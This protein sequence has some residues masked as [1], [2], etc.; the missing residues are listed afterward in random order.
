DLCG[1]AYNGYLYTVGGVEATGTNGTT[2]G[3]VQRAPFHHPVDGTIGSWIKQTGLGLPPVQLHGTVVLNGY[4]YVIGG[5]TYKDVSSPA[6]A[7][8]AAVYVAQISTTDGSV[9]SFT[10]LTAT[11]LPIPLYKTCPVVV[12]NTIYMFGGETNAANQIVPGYPTVN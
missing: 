7:I 10:K 2:V 9:G 11:P 3:Y 8:T 1:V 6:S 12:G 5:S 4:M